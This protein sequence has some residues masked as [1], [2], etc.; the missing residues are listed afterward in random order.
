MSAKIDGVARAGDDFTEPN[1]RFAVL[2]ETFGRSI[3]AGAIQHDDHADAAVERAQHFG[4]ADASGSRKPLEYRQHRNPSELQRNAEPGGS[5]RG[6]FSVKPPPVMWA[7]ALTA[8]V[9][10]M[11]ARQDRT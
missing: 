8:L 10:R 9:V 2:G 3:G 7:R 11:A 6:I 5:T 4:F 1:H